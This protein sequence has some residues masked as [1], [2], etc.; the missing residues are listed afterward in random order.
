MKITLPKLKLPKALRSVKAPKLPD[1]PDLPE[2]DMKDARHH[3]YD[4]L[5]A[6]LF[7]GRR[8]AAYRRLV[9]A[10]EVLPA[11]AVVDVGCGTGQFTR[12]LREVAGPDSVIGVDPDASAVQFAREKSKDITY[13]VGEAD[14]LPVTDHS[15][16]LVTSALSFHHVDPA[17]RDAAIA[18]AKRVLRP[19]GRLAIVDL[20]KPANP[21]SAA[22]FGWHPC[23]RAAEPV[24]DLVARLASAGFTD[25][26]S[27]PYWN[28]MTVV[29]GTA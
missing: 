9:R 3:A 29:K 6:A 23:V 10:L 2:I 8:T 13:R 19:G 28:W 7:G 15:V 21:V 17:R 18:E 20:A 16:D 25:I 1:L 26:A 4:A 14:A 11:H 22:A 5:S 24:D 12:L 27:K